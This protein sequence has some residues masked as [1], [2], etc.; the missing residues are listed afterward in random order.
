MP[1]GISEAAYTSQTPPAQTFDADSSAVK[2]LTGTAKAGG[3]E[4]GDTCVCVFAQVGRAV[5]EV[6]STEGV[7]DPA[8]R[9]TFFQ[10]AI[11]KVKATL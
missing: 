8:N 5:V 4:M 6:H 11:D 2:Y 3:S 7:F 1:L 9:S 10:T